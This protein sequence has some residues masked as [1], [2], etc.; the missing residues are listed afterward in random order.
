MKI[1]VAGEVLANQLG[2]DDL[3]VALDH[4]AVGLARKD[5]LSDAGHRQRIDEPGDKRERDQNNDRRTDFA[6]HDVVSLSQMQ[7][8]DD[9]VD[10][11]DADERNQH[12]AAAIDQKILQQ[13]RAG[14]DRPVTHAFE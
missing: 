13:Q 7:G 6:Q 4:A 14:A 2:T 9:H 11:F 1:F 3:P 8:G 5:E 12:A 10:H